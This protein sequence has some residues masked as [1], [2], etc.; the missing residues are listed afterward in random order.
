[1]SCNAKGINCV[2]N[3][4]D[5]LGEVPVWDTIN[6]CLWWVDVLKPAIH[7]M[8]YTSGKLCSWTPPEKIHSFGLRKET[9][10][11]V[12][13]RKGF[14]FYDP[15]AN[16]FD[17]LHD[18]IGLDGNTLLNDGRVDRQGRFWVGSM[19]KMLTEPSG[20]LYCFDR[21]LKCQSASHGITLSNGIA[22]SPNG[23][24]LYLA[25][26][27][28]K[29]I[30]AFDLDQELGSLKNKRIFADTGDVPGMPDG[31]AVDSDG[32][33]WSARFDGGKLLRHSPEGEIIEE[34]RFPVSRV[35]ACAFGGADL[36]TLFVTSGFFRLSK[37]QLAVEPLA[38]A[39]FS[40]EVEIP[41]VPEPR[42]GR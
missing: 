13:S 1:M 14:A 6:G 35:T 28:P 23:G 30:Y 42:F 17:F 8:D 27:V 26:S 11:I 19:D 40:V 22:I 16:I 31:A 9:G 25:D 41:G 7:R 37:E 38:G 3:T 32:C 10:L 24:T 33:L 12:A 5:V 15:E 2:A 29:L 34:I 18:P 36:K 20:H 39:L 4:A 21:A